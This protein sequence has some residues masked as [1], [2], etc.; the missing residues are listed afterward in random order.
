MTGL[1]SI[2]LF[3]VSAKSN[4]HRVAEAIYK[5]YLEGKGI[6]VQAI[7]GGAVNQ[8]A[9]SIAIASGKLSTAGWHISVIIGF[10]DIPDV[11]KG[12]ISA[13]NFS[14]IDVHGAHNG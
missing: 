12:T 10:R 13:L 2:A 14:L 8:A 11:T 4:I 5:T 1:K 3:R 6:E 9:K 7:G